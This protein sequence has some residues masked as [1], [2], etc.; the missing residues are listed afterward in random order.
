M[1]GLSLPCKQDSFILFNS[2]PYPMGFPAEIPLFYWSYK[3]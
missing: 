1:N 3:D 2:S